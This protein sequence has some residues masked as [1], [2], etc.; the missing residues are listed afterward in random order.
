MET[1]FDDDEEFAQ[2]RLECLEHFAMQEEST[3]TFNGCFAPAWMCLIAHDRVNV[4]S[5][6]YRGTYTFMPQDRGNV[7]QAFQRG[8]SNTE[9]QALR[10]AD[11]KLDAISGPHD[12]DRIRRNYYL[13]PSWRDFTRI[14]L[15]ETEFN[16][17]NAP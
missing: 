6:T 10:C 5:R 14:L 2:D 15:G 17:L 4:G 3:K 12:T 1:V 11:P 9:R 8:H 16:R 13:N 7:T